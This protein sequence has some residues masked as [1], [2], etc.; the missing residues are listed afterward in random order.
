M[1]HCIFDGGGWAI[2][3]TNSGTKVLWKVSHQKV[4]VICGT[5]WQKVEVR[6]KILRRNY[7]QP[8]PP[9]LQIITVQPLKT[10]AFDPPPLP[11]FGI[12]GGWVWWVWIFSETA[13]LM[14][15]INPSWTLS[16]V[17]VRG[18][19]NSRAFNCALK[20]CHT[21][22]GSFQCPGPA[23]GIISYWWSPYHSTILVKLY[24]ESYN[25]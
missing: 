6:E 13:H 20:V 18:L 3:Q 8:P 16:G 23:K 19:G 12:L 11:N 15:I 25:E 5:N 2:A 4:Q 7:A 14:P 22:S 21:W 17:I 10:L 24:Q 9:L 1:G